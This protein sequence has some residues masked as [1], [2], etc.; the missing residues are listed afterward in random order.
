MG[1]VNEF[2]EFV[3]RGN[4]I[5]LA[6]GVIIGAAFNGVVQSLVDDVIMP[7]IGLLIGGLDFSDLAIPLR[8]TPD[9]V[10]AIRYGAFINTLI[11]FLITALAVF[12]VIR[13]INRLYVVR[14]GETPAEKEEPVIKECPYCFQEIPIQAKRCPFC[15]S[16]L[17]GVNP[18]PVEGGTQ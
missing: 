18:V 9:G 6:V 13:M 17:T 11:A 15:T 4:V 3:M 1:F 7:P 16:Q 10:V 8:Q 2:K 5:D 12:L 14:R